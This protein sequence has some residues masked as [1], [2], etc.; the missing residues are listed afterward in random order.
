MRSCL[1]GVSAKCLPFK[2][3]LYLKLWFSIVLCTVLQSRDPTPPLP[4]MMFTS[5]EPISPKPPQD[6]ASSPASN[7]GGGVLRQVA[8]LSPSDD[9]IQQG[10]TNRARL[11]GTET[12]VYSG[13]NL[14]LCPNNVVLRLGFCWTIYRARNKGLYVVARNFFLLLL[15][16]SAWPCLAVA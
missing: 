15:N 11:I 8:P 12:G 10:L 4:C 3:F 1:L 6:V 16:C 7:S 14:L 9:S 13:P 2:R 5:L